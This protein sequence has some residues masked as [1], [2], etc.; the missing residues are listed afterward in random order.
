MTSEDEDKILAQHGAG[1]GSAAPV[2]SNAGTKPMTPE[3]E[4]AILARHGVAPQ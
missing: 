1:S 2:I 3:E 4:D